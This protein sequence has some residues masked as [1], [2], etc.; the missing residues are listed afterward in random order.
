MTELNAIMGKPGKM[1]TAKEIGGV[2]FA[3]SGLLRPCLVAA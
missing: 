2:E 3:A 1:R